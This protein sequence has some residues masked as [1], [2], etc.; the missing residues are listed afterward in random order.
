[1]LVPCLFCTLPPV[2]N[3]FPSSSPST[4]PGNWQA[5]KPQNKR[6]KGEDRKKAKRRHHHHHGRW[7]GENDVSY[8]FHNMLPDV[9]ITHFSLR[10]IT[11]LRLLLM[12]DKYGLFILMIKT[13]NQCLGSSL[14][15]RFLQRSEYLAHQKFSFLLKFLLVSNL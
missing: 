14:Q 5:P 2:S 15:I 13:S 12:D 9:F 8:P 7:T 6:K 4:V 3:P 1:M 11:I 10:N